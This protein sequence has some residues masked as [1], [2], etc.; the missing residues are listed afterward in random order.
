MAGKGTRITL[1]KERTLRYDLNALDLIGEKL[2]ITIRFGMVD[3]D[4]LNTP[5]PLGALRTILWAGLRHED[6]S[7]TEEQVGA[8][9]GQDNMREVIDTFFGLFG[10]TGPADAAKET[11]TPERRADMDDMGVLASARLS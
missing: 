7:L 4:L 5:M 11:V 3:E 8:W 10:A 2:G 1:D 9:V 6:S